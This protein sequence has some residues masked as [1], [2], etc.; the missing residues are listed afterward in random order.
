MSI[1]LYCIA[2]RTT[3][4][5]D[6]PKGTA[7]I[8]VDCIQT[9][10]LVAFISSAP[11]PAVWLK[12]PL[13]T[14]AIEF[15]R[16]CDQIFKSGAII[17]FRFPTIFESEEKLQEHVSQRSEQYTSLLIQFRNVVQ[18]ELHMSG[19]NLHVPSQSG[20]EYLKQRQNSLY[21]IE[22]FSNEVRGKVSAAIKDWRERR[23]KEGI[24]GF[25]LVER[26]RI[27]VFQNAL[28]TIPVPNGFTVRVSG[29]WPAIEF[30]E[31]P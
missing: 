24:R 15:H 11:D 1:L 17:P 10:E 31:Q 18:M 9:D 25:A 14:A 23:S 28:R 19:E 5:G 27:E 6:L 13:H 30:M 7:G 20:T 29:P 12:S 16:V 21:A 26:D 3:Q 4:P 2:S 22:Q 8:S